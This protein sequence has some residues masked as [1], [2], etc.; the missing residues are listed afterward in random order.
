MLKKLQSVSLKPSLGR[1][2]TLQFTT[3]NGRSLVLWRQYGNIQSLRDSLRVQMHKAA[4]CL[5]LSHISIAGLSLA[6]C[7]SCLG[8][9]TWGRGWEPRILSSL[10]STQ[11]TISGL[12]PSQIKDRVGRASQLWECLFGGSVPQFVV[13]IQ[14]ENHQIR[15]EGVWKTKHPFVSDPHKLESHILNPFNPQFSQLSGFTLSIPSWQL[16]HGPQK[17]S[18][19]FLS[20]GRIQSASSWS[21]PR[22]SWI[23]SIK[24]WP[25][26]SWQE[27]WGLSRHLGDLPSSQLSLF[28]D[29]HCM[30]CSYVGEG[31]L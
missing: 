23:G 24:P 15:G 14:K 12:K 27:A 5:A 19:L 16:K 13:E 6:C 26:R 30:C 18:H 22:I 21:P 29:L 8:E 25:V 1:T 10:T 28:P 7:F 9:K 20:G 2:G 11:S 17:V 4:Y 3:K 31:S